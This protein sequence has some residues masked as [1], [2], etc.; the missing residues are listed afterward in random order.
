MHDP[1]LPAPAVAPHADG[2]DHD[3]R[4]LFGLAAG[5]VALAGGVFAANPARADS[6]TREQRDALT[7]DQV[8]KMV[9]DGNARFVAG[10]RKPRNFLAE[11]RSS[12]TNGQFP[13]AVFL[14]CVDSRAPVEVI[15]DLG[16]GEAF[17][18]RV[19]GNAVNDD[20]LGSM[21]FATAAAGARLV[22]VMGHT[23]CGAIKGAIDGVRL[24]NLTL[25]LARFGNAIAATEFKGEKS[26]KNA[27]YVDAVATTH[28]R[29]TVQLIRERSP[30]MR[31]LEQ[32]GRIRIVGS[33][34]D[35]ASGRVGLVA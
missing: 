32:E 7:P 12:A 23:A 16:I 30:T 33:M 18:A 13:A 6:L 25:L 20:M 1:Q 8:L 2:C 15:C 19:A 26:G 29:L 35:L 34:Y 11:Q 10:E 3:R 9:M 4:R 5:A 17:N 21:E 22:M 27:A 28:V 24:G 14:S 31:A